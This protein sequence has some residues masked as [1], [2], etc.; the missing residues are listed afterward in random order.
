MSEVSLYQQRYHHAKLVSGLIV[1]SIL[2]L[3]TLKT[4]AS[5]R[6]PTFGNPLQDAGVPAPTQVQGYVAHKKQRPHRSLP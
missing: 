2:V 4:S 3:L 6:E 5:Q 1:S